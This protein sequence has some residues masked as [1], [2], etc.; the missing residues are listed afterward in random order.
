MSQKSLISVIT[1]TRNDLDG[2]RLTCDSVESQSF[3]SYEHIII[4]GCSSDGTLNFLNNLISTK[5]IWESEADRGIYHALNKG[6]KLASGSWIIFMNSGD[7][8]KS[9]TVLENVLSIFIEVIQISS[10]GIMKFTTLMEKR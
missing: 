8:F 6:A 5:V 1:I 7:V 10:L 2:L 3:G 4:D 9:S